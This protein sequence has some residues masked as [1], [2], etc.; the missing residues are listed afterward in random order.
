MVNMIENKKSNFIVIRIKIMKEAIIINGRQYKKGVI[1]E[2]K[3]VWFVHMTN[4]WAPYKIDENIA[5]AI[6]VPQSIVTEYIIKIF[7]I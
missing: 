4:N 1:S 2:D 3:I 7:N 5:I 6:I